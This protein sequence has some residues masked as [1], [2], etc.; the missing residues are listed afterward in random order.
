MRDATA[1]VSKDARWGSGC[2]GHPEVSSVGS[3][4]EDTATPKKTDKTGTFETIQFTTI[5]VYFGRT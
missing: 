2:P 4:F 3:R 1:A 5:L